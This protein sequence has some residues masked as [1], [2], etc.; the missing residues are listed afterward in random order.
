M[1]PVVLQPMILL[2]VFSA[3]PSLIN[4]LAIGNLVN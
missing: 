2:M 4:N 1:R 3:D